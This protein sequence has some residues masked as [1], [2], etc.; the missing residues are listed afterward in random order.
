MRPGYRAAAVANMASSSGV[1]EPRSASCPP[2]ATNCGN[3]AARRSRP[4]WSVS[5]LTT[6]S[7]SA[8]GSRSSSS[9]RCTRLPIGFLAP[10]RPQAVGRSDHADRSRD[11]RPRRRSR[12][13]CRRDLPALPAKEPSKPMPNCGV[14]SSTRIG[15]ADRGQAIREDKPRL[16]ERYLAVDTRIPSGVKPAAVRPRAGA[17]AAAKTA[18]E[19][20]VV[21]REDTGG[22]VR[23]AACR[24]RSASGRPASR[25]NA[26]HRRA[27]RRAFPRRCGPPPAPARRSAGG[28]RASPARRDRDRGCP[29]GRRDGAHRARMFADAVLRL[30]ATRIAPARRRDHRMPR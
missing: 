29:A 22:G 18:R 28:Y 8:A 7:R 14:C 20:D 19:G 23:H 2:A 4:F 17:F 3:A 11:S 5:R 25:G 9:S 26:R 10:E 16:Q 15:R 12:S 27:S 24:D 30:A 6:Q 21:D 1:P 13:G